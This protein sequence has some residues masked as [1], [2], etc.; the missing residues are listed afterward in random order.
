V[1][2]MLSAIIVCSVI[3]LF[4]PRFSRGTIAIVAGVATV[5]TALYYI[6]PLRFM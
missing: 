6:F 4:A 5:M 3:G 2:L 1:N